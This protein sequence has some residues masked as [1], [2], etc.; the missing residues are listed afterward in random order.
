MLAGTQHLLTQ[1]KVIADPV[2]FRL[3]A[4]C[5]HGECSVSEFTGILGLSQPRISQHLKLLC[6]AGLVER[7]RDGQRVYY[8]LPA[9]GRQARHRRQ[10]LRL[11]PEEEPQFADDASQLR[12]DL[13][14]V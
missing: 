6:D 5:R 8:R 13:V 9:Q 4:L 2:R 3:L 12:N 11:L 14:I 1:L 10:L 7:F